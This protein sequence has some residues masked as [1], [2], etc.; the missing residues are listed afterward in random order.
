V[1]FALSATRTAR[2]ANPSRLGE[3]K[4]SMARSKGG[5]VLRTGRPKRH[6]EATLCSRRYR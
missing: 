1:S 3:R 4:A 6:S 2:L 5:T